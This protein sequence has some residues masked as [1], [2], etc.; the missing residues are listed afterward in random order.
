M[1]KNLLVVDDDEDI[2]ALLEAYLTGKGFNVIAAG[3]GK[4]GLEKYQADFDGL[5]ITDLDMP[6]MDGIE[7]LKR[8][9]EIDP[10][11]IG[12]ILTGK[13]C[14]ETCITSLRDGLAYDYLL[15]PL[16]NMDLLLTACQRAWEKKDLEFHN[17]DLM[18]SLK[19]S[20][21]D[22]QLASKVFENA[23]E[24]IIVTDRDAVI[25][26]V[27]PSFTSITGYG[28][29]EAVGKKTSILKSDRHDKAF[30]ED[31]WK[32]LLSSGQWQGRIWNRRKNGEAF[33]IRLTITS[34][35]DASG[36]TTHYS[37]IFYD[38][39]ENKKEQDHIKSLA[40][41]DALTGLPNRLLFNDRLA[42]AIESGRRAIRR[43]F[44]CFFWIWTISRKSM[45]ALAIKSGTCC[46][47]RRHCACPA[48]CG[49]KIRFQGAE[50]MNSLFCL[51]AMA[52]GAII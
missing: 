18:D 41:H 11:C 17:R 12:I 39:T 35:K 32:A 36:R 45:T 25:Q 20:N 15:K 9:K 14:A 10:D 38:I 5:V 34:V 27:N 42:H 3:S 16:E 21:E 29:G 37:C 33:L 46:L 30:F 50:E 4:E 24:G 52:R 23:V 22:L 8:L 31:M 6:E 49:R 47:P 44:P 51:R 28:V 40:Y 7:F 2:R 19:K 48:A 43:S 1:K 26:K 13:G